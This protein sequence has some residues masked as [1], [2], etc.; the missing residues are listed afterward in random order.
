MSGAIRRPEKSSRLWIH[1]SIFRSA[2]FSSIPNSIPSPGGSGCRPRYLAQYIDLKHPVDCRLDKARPHRLWIQQN[3]SKSMHLM[4]IPHSVPSPSTP[5]GRGGQLRCLAQYIDLKH[6]VD[7]RL[8]KARPHRLWIQQNSSKSMHLMN[9]P[10]SVPSPSTPGGSGGR[11]RC[12][13]QYIDLKHPVDCRLDK[14]RPHR[15]WIQQ[16]SSKSMHLMNIPHS[17]PSPSGRGLG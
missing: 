1:H 10:H 6:P 14:A 11:P 2:Y 5:G 4:N 15:L 16:N 8:D 17:V 12:L 9:I 3:S 13:V 7:C